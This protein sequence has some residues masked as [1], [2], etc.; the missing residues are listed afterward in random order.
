MNSS[1][2]YF[3]EELENVRRSQEKLENSFVEMQAELK[4]MKNRMNNAQEQISDLEESN[5]N[6][7]IRTVDR[8]PNEENM[9]AI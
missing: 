6:H 7:P 9:E 5:G 3:R 4:A 1:A 8:K 2:N